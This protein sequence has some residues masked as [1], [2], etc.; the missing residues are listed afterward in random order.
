[1]LKF[2]EQFPEIIAVMSEKEDGPTKLLDGENGRQNLKNREIFFQK[3][4]IDPKKVVSAALAHGTSAVIVANNSEK[5]IKGIDGFVTNSENVFLA[6]TISDC[7]PV[8]FYEKEKGIIALAHAGWRGIV[9]NI[10]E[11]TIQKIAEL[12][13]NPHKL[14][15]S[16]G[17]GINS[18]HFEIKND[19]LDEFA[20]YGEFILHR[21]GK[22]FVDLKGIIK[23]QLLEKGVSDKNIENKAE[24]TYCS[25]NF[26]SFRRNKTTETMLA[27]IGLQKID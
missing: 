11:N 8:F 21:S 6:I 27:I 20:D 18:C 1:M 12:G 14:Y 2:F 25:K 15:V 7:V 5:L 9:G 26:F 19:V 13:G 3:C 23:K 17:P 4:E 22:L 16:L 24:C 10:V